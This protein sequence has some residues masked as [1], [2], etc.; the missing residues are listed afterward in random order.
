[1][2]EIPSNRKSFIESSIEVA[3]RYGFQ[4]IDL[5]WPW[6]NTA[7]GTITMEKL[8]DEWRAAVTSEARN[9]GLPRLKL[10][11]A[12][13]YIPTFESFIYPVESM[14]RNLDWAH[15]VAYDYHLPLK[16]NFIGAHAA[17]KGQCWKFIPCSNLTLK[18]FQLLQR[19]LAQ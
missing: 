19:R 4:G 11:M 9:S 7:S 5:L 6:L 15:V 16:E 13:R 8:L 17:F 2:L 14:K 3:R 12:V 10:T 1:M 18:P